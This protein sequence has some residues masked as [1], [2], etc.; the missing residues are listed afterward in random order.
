MKTL[1]LTK[2]IRDFRGRPM[3][4]QSGEI[5]GNGTPIMIPMLMKDIYLHYLGVYTSQNGKQVIAAYKLGIAIVDCKDPEMEIENADFLLLKEA[6]Q[7]PMHGALVMGQVYEEL[8][9]VGK[10]P[11]KKKEK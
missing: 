9:R 3:N 8:D 2:S 11:E 5:D 10:E 7:K 6:T 1:P 4:Q